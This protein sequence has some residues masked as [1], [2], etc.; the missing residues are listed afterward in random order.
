MKSKTMNILFIIP[1]LL[2]V[3]SSPSF[4]GNAYCSLLKQYININVDPINV[5][6]ALPV[7]GSISGILTFDDVDYA[8]CKSTGNA[9]AYDGWVNGNRVPVG[10]SEMGAIFATNLK[11]IGIKFGANFPGYGN[12][13]VYLSHF[14]DRSGYFTQSMG[15]GIKYTLTAA[16]KINLIKLSKIYETGTLHGIVGSVG[17]ATDHDPSNRIDTDVIINGTITA[18]SCEIESGQNLSIAL[19][20]VHKSD[21]PSIG[22]TW[23]ESEKSNIILSCNTGTKVYITFNGEQA[24]GSADKSILQNNGNAQGIGVQ[25]LDSK[26]VPFNL[27]EKVEEISSTGTEA[28]IPVSARYIRT[29]DLV[30]G[31]VDSSATYTLDYE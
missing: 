1:A 12:F 21:L 3:F 7:N 31:S 4:A 5:S 6:P 9:D 23:G 25:L 17:V 10:V 22:S 13:W 27:G 2:L 29:G 26:G 8:T 16:P 15:A 11:G 14:N 18:G 20:D 30:S 28:T 19:D 24:K